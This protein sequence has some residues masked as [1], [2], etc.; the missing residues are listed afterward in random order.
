MRIKVLAFGDCSL[1]IS[2]TPVMANSIVAMKFGIVF[3]ALRCSNLT[4]LSEHK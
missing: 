2:Q 1:G 4:L 3:S